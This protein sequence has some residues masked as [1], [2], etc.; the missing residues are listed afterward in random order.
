[1]TVGLP[2]IPRLPFRTVVH[3]NYPDVGSSA[4]VHL[5]NLQGR[6]PAGNLNRCAAHV[7]PTSAVLA[8]EGQANAVW[9]VFTGGP[10]H[11]LSE[12]SIHHCVLQ[13]KGTVL[14]LLLK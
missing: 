9:I 12:S 13:S 2:V 4:L 3:R 1:M 5:S 11:P 6:V 8:P 10:D 14:R 7:G